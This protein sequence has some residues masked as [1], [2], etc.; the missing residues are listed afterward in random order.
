ML[1]LAL[2]MAG[3][4][5]GPAAPASAANCDGLPGSGGAWSGEYTMTDNCTLTGTI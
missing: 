5:A 3:L 1:I 2:L 4:A